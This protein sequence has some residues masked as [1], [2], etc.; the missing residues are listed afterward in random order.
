MTDEKLEKLED[1]IKSLDKEQLQNMAATCLYSLI[2]SD[3]VKYYPEDEDL[4]H[5]PYWESSGETLI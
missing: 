2:E 3:I 1:W 5:T 4:P